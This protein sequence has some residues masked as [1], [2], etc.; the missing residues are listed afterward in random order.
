[1]R[2]YSQTTGVWI[3]GVLQDDFGISAEQIRWITFEGAHVA[4]I[5]D[6]AWAE[7]A[8]AG[9]DM[10]AMLRAGELDAVIV[11]N[12]VPDDPVFRTVFPIRKRPQTGFVPSMAS[13]R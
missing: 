11:G 2:A 3:R 1:M 6:P 9:Q 10:L 5:S 12:E 7:R 4:E 13:C 8:G